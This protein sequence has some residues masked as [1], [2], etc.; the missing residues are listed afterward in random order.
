MAPASI[1]G[2]V[3][4]DDVEV[5]A[6]LYQRD[7]AAGYAIELPFLRGLTSRYEG[8]LAQHDGDEGRD[9][10]YHGQKCIPKRIGLVEGELFWG[11]DL[12]TQSVGAAIL[13]GRPPTRALEP[14]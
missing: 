5:L 11:D 3:R 10:C 4:R 7:P 6:V 12:T 13:I 2:G 1:Q 14:L 8:R 9:E